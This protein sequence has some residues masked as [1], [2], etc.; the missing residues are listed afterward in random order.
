MESAEKMKVEIWSDIMCPFFYI[1]KRKFE[2]A[3]E[4][5][6]HTEQTQIIWRSYQLDPNISYQPGRDLYS[7]LAERK[8]QTLDWSKNMHR[9]V[10]DMAKEVGLEYNFDKAVIANSF[11]AHRLIHLAKKYDL[12]DE[13]EERL[14]KAYFTEGQ[15]VSDH[16][17]LT[18]LG[19]E[20][21]L[22]KQEVEQMLIS[23]L[24]A[25]AVINDG[26]EAQQIGARGVPFF[27]MDR[28]YG[29]SGAQPAEAF[30]QTLEK[31][32]SDWQKTHPHVSID[33]LD[34]EVCTP[35]GNCN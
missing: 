29:V 1:G 21:G 7:Y 31:S 4:R 26:V 14:F 33:T 6:P 3:L 9:Q 18:Q 30:L 19:V 8:G 22:D 25:E 24:Y 2:Q 13:A 5:F 16:K 28:K 12:G 15:N 34:G 10:A 35:E 27:V 20:I 17:V 11:D 32:F 23:D